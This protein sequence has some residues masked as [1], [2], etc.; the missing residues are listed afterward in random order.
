MDS[1]LLNGLSRRIFSLLP[2]WLRCFF[3]SLAF[4]G[5]LRVGKSS[6]IHPSVHVLGKS[7]IQIGHNSCISEGV[8]LN[9]NHRVS[10]KISIYIG[11]NCFIGKS[12]FF[13]CGDEIFISDFVLTAIG[14]K[15]IGSTHIFNDPA[16]P[17]MA[18][19]TTCNDRIVVGL[20]CFFGAG[21][22]VMGNISIGRG[23]I[24]GA[25]SF[26]LE[27]VP[28]FSIVIGNPAKVVKRYSFIK[29]M[30]LPV[31]LLSDCDERA[32]PSEQDYLDILKL[33]YPVVNMPWIAAGKSMGD[34]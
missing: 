14:C 22:T 12:N 23:S 18:T 25:N 32:M 4:F 27:N 1:L 20:N 29:K 21:T 11:S 31:T 26:V 28:P 19:G 7:N 3:Q 8:W 6:Y 16:T 10:K 17:Y 5:V 30:W 34:L 15:F 33:N 2:I 24:I 9:V 13:S